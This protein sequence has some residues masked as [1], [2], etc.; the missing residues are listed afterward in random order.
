MAG[1][2]GGAGGGLKV[3]ADGHLGVDQDVTEPG[4]RTAREQ[5]LDRFDRV[6]EP[7][8][9]VPGDVLGVARA[10]STG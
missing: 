9:V 6:V 4:S 10:R 7:P 3:L 5:V 1:G 8:T 2:G